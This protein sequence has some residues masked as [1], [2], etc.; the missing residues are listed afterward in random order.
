MTDIRKIDDDPF[1]RRF[2][3][4]VDG[5]GNSRRSTFT[6][7]TEN[8]MQV[9]GEET[10]TLEWTVQGEFEMVGLMRAFALCL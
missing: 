9:N 10:H 3:L 7:E 8:P 6:I 2:E 4:S 1:V 5:N